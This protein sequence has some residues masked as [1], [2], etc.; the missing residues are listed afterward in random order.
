M[1]EFIKCFMKLCIAC[2]LIAGVLLI[3]IAVLLLL[4]P[5]ALCEII[6]VSIALLCLAG[7]VWLIGSLLA[8]VFQK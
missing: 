3:G 6:K 4:C 5:A 2:S 7:G 8:A 1:D